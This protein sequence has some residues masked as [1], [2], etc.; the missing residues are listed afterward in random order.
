VIRHC[1]HGAVSDSETVFISD[2]TVVTTTTYK[3]MIGSASNRLAQYSAT[4]TDE[5]RRVRAYIFLDPAA[6]HVSNRVLW[7]VIMRLCLSRIQLSSY[8]TC[9]N[10]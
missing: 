2:V 8:L 6:N 1:P 7:T 4:K 10:V 9:S 5:L 3:D